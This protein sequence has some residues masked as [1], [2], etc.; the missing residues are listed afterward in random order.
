MTEPASAEGADS[1][2]EALLPLGDFVYRPLSVTERFWTSFRLIFALPWRRF[3]KGSI[4]A[5]EVCPVLPPSRP[6]PHIC[7]VSVVE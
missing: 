6:F 1:T 4:L 5:F 3:K 7:S 2:A